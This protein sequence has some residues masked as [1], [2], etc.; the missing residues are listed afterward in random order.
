MRR[1]MD[2]AA[3]SVLAG[4]AVLLALTGC[5][6]SSD[7]PEPV[8][9]P[10]YEARTVVLQE[11]HAG[12]P[13]GSRPMRFVGDTTV[14]G[15]TFG[16][17]QVGNFERAEPDGEEWWVSISDAQVAFAGGQVFYPSAPLPGGVP[18]I[19]ATV[20]AP[21][22]VSLGTPLDEPQVV[23]AS[24][25]VVIG[26]P[27]GAHA[28]VSVSEDVTITRVAEGEVVETFAGDYAAADHYHAEATIQ[29]QPASAE[30]WWVDGVGPVRAEYEWAGLAGDHG[31]AL[32]AIVSALAADAGYQNLM[33]EQLLDEVHP[34]F[35]VNSYDVN[36]AFDADK[37]TH[38]KM[39]AEFRWADV[40]RAR[41]DDPVPVGPDF[42]TAWGVFPA[43]LVRTEVSLFHPEEAGQGFRYWQAVVDQAA[44]NE[45]TNGISYHAGGVW[46]PIYAPS[47]PSGPVRGSAVVLYK[48][49]PAP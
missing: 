20:D 10:P 32:Q 31:M 44:K 14:S 36:Q 19:S 6:P 15:Q 35:S 1:L 11:W 22:V 30:V 16:R 45:A 4:A 2:D 48:R 3:P 34:R 12:E 39:V 41:T 46:D 38:A 17:L 33:G 5:G 42:G 43:A 23:H 25:S 28:T 37:D 9:Q 13:G 27:A 7:R 40:E 47:A 8:Y 21:L 24:G 49:W 26:D 29:D 18:N